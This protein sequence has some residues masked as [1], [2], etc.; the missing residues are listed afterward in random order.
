MGAVGCKDEGD[1][2]LLWALV[3]RLGEAQ[4]PENQ[5]R[6][7][8]RKNISTGSEDL[9]IRGKWLELQTVQVSAQC[10]SRPEGCKGI[11]RILWRARLD[12]VFFKHQ[13]KPREHANNHY[14]GVFALVKVQ[15]RTQN[16]WQGAEGIYYRHRLEKCWKSSK[17][18]EVEITL[19]LTKARSYHF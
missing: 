18:W 1:S 11:Q 15:S 16:P 17:R 3:K 10:P 5:Q 13:Q 9:S 7:G 14:W 12:Y 2:G 4:R 8:I 6:L 19:K